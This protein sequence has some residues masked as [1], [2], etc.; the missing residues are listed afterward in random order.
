MRV[1]VTKMA[2]IFGLALLAMGLFAGGYLAGQTRV[3]QPKTIIHVVEIQCNRG[4]P[5]M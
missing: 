3:G 4:V 1:Q 5:H 2:R